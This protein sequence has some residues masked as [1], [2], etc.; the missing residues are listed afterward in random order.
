MT[1]THTHL[2]VHQRNKRDLRQQPTPP[3]HTMPRSRTTNM[4]KLSTL[5]APDTC[6]YVARSST[7]IFTSTSPPGSVGQVMSTGMGVC[8]SPWWPPTT[9]RRMSVA[10]PTTH[11]TQQVRVMIRATHTGTRSTLATRL[12]R[13]VTA[14]GAALG[15]ATVA[16]EGGDRG[17]VLRRL[18]KH[19]RPLLGPQLPSHHGVG[20]DTWPGLRN[21]TVLVL[22]T[23]R[24]A[25]C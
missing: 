19:K 24:G 18:F 22:R 20:A 6:M 7:H 21:V 17:M 10:T 15:D 4:C 14:N 25:T 3:R 8:E 12:S 5:H 2:S 13:R 23:V 11:T 9:A 1:R 16:R